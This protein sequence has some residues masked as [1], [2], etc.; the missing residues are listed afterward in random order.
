MIILF[1]RE[2]SSREVGIFEFEFE[3]HFLSSRRVIRLDN[4]S[5]SVLFE[6]DLTFL[7][8]N[9]MFLTVK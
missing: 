1:D 9:V 8:E 5:Y 6:I 4:E 7:N 2:S 3:F